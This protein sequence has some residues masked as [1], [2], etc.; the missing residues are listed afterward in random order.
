MSTLEHVTVGFDGGDPDGNS[1]SPAIS[2]DGQFVAFSSQADNLVPNDLNAAS[3]VFLFNRL[4]NSLELVSRAA[5]GDQGDA[6]SG[7]N[8]SPALSA[9][10]NFV[11]FA[12]EATNLVPGDTNG[13]ADVFLVDRQT[14]AVTRISTS[15]LGAVEDGGSSGP[16]MSDDARWIA[17]VSSADNLVAGDGNGHPD[18]FLLDRSS[19]DLERISDGAFALGLDKVEIGDGAPSIS[20]DGRYLTFGTGAELLG[21]LTPD[22]DE[23][24]PVPTTPNIEV[25]TF[26]FDRV[27]GDT[28]FLGVE[29]TYTQ[30]AYDTLDPSQATISADGSK[31]A[32]VHGE[33]VLPDLF[34]LAT[35]DVLS[36]VERATGDEVY[37]AD[38]A[39]GR[40]SVPL[41]ITSPS[42][43][44][45]GDTLA[46]VQDF[47]LTGPGFLFK[48]VDLGTGDSLTPITGSF[49]SGGMISDDG[50]ALAF[51]RG[52]IFG[53][54]TTFQN[55]FVLDSGDQPFGVLPPSTEGEAVQP[56]II[57]TYGGVAPAALTIGASGDASITFLDEVARFQSM[58]GVY[59]VGSDGTIH[60]A[61]M[62]F[63]RIEHADADPSL[64]S[65]VRP[66]GGPLHT[67][68]TVQLSDLYD[69]AK[70]APGQG[71]SLFLIADG[72]ER[73]A[74]GYFD[75]TRDTLHFVAADGITPA[76]VD[77]PAPKLVFDTP[78]DATPNKIF[79]D[80][81]HALNENTFPTLDNPLNPDGKEH[82]LAGQLLDGS[83][84]VRFED[85]AGGR[86]DKD[87]N[88]VTIAVSTS[89][90]LDLLLTT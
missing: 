19:G 90:P 64:P 89:P 66:G 14:D 53:A 38:A 27:T 87:F 18:V 60:D 26:V 63:D 43:D 52:D 67:G 17:F 20:A 39:R 84:E 32:F 45:H 88:D 73:N 51:A 4:T 13:V 75:P 21:T 55:I 9:E 16:A 68:D 31:V 70:L 34:G 30:Q 35:G 6:D 1:F 36:V 50:Q 78:G 10:G 81:L 25:G 24:L 69:P 22:G 41:D 3:D 54:P 77:D 86:S 46:Y 23:T 57:E 48:L 28:S 61:K 7:L 72:A 15:E 74:N 49:S 37:S 33:V 79:G 2:P 56:N 76:T 80:V 82:V 42:L 5:T 47:G 29:T 40:Y 83:L 62:V 44:G 71:F 8:S 59:L 85:I 12:S 11:A 65:S 58:L